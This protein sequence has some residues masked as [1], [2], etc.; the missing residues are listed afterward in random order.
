M[1]LV[2]AYF[3]WRMRRAKARAEGGGIRASPSA[4]EQ[5]NPEEALLGERTI[6]AHHKQTAGEE[7]EPNESEGCSIP[8]I[9]RPVIPNDFAGP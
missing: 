3:R 2:D 4:H 5:L 6:I 1:S 9:K 7:I 8:Q